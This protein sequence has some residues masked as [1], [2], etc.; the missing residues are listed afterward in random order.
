ME[1]T[2]RKSESTEKYKSFAELTL[3][4]IVDRH[5]LLHDEVLPVEVGNLE[6][7][8]RITL[9]E[10]YEHKTNVKVDSPASEAI[11]NFRELDDG[12]YVLA[13]NDDDVVEFDEW[14]ELV[15]ELTDRI[16][17]LL[18]RRLEKMLEFE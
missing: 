1:P 14:N 4:L 13:T 5:V 9:R 11:I 16:K 2:H 12:T 15:E 17:T 3:A 8:G 18:L 7:R 6:G 10:Q